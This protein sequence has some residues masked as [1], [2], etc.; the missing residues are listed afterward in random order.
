MN[1]PSKLVKI[2]PQFI[3]SIVDHT[4]NIAIRDSKRIIVDIVPD[5]QR[6]GPII[7]PYC[8]QNHDEFEISTCIAIH[9]PLM[10]IGSPN[11]INNLTQQIL[12]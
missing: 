9:L 4:A 10:K 7:Q 1:L 8:Q 12:T 6:A 3:M 2:L 11:L 5:F